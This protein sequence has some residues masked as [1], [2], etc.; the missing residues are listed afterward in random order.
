M[1]HRDA[2]I[3]RYF[4]EPRFENFEIRQS[5]LLHAKTPTTWALA[6][7]GPTGTGLLGI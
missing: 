7:E 6:V 3:I 5:L 2:R 4:N 1:Q